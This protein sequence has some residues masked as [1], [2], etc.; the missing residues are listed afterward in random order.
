MKKKIAILGST[1]S[2]GKTLL[3]ALSKDKKNIDIILLTASKNYKDLITQ[4]KKFNVRNVIITD[5]QSYKKFKIL[6]NNKKL[7]IFNDF[8]S[9]NKIFT[10]KVD[11]VMSS[12]VGIDG[13]FPTMNIIKFTKKIAIANKESIICAWNLIKN[14]LKK[15]NTE[16]IPV[17]SEH[18][19][20][21]YAIK[22]IPLSTISKIYLTASGGPLLKI[23]KRNYK[24][25]KLNKI[26]KH[27]NWSMGK[28]ISVDSSTMMNKVFEVIEAKKIFNLPYKKIS[29]LI[30]PKSYIHAIILFNDSMIKIISHETTMRIPISNTL[31]DLI[32]KKYKISNNK[33]IKI[34][35]KKLND[36]ELK[37]IS[38]SKFPAVNIISKLPSKDSLFET[39]LVSANDEFVSLFLQ[40]K[41]T[42]TELLVKLM[43]FISKKRF[44]KY[45]TIAPYKINDIL[46]L[47]QKIKLL[48]NPA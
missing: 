40:K 9:F 15:N 35:F 20:I 11:Y 41:I 3:K 36:P 39:I 43:K 30:H 37:N 24:K 34:N 2:I 31:S 1:G 28:K 47:N 10:S 12:I 17:D 18:F 45:K 19:S 8:N 23:P 13:L 26:I 44:K 38:S 21:W 46:E 16:F 32:P 22:N 42:Y 27:P 29:I 33:A 48:I 5:D 7:K 14:E 4:T 25:I 6:N